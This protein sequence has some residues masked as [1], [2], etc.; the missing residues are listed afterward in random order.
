MAI[1]RIIKAAVER[2]ASDVHIKAGD[3]VRARIDGRLVVLTKQALTAEQ[4]RAIALHFMMSDAE[5]GTID[6]LKDHDCS[7][8][9][10]GVGRFRVNIMRQRAAHSIVMRVIPEIVPTFQS[11]KLPPVLDR[12][13]H[14]ERGMVLVTGVTG[15]GKSSTMAALVNAINASQEKHILTLENPIEFIHADLKSSVTQ[16]EVGID[17]ESFRMGLRAA[18]RQDPDVILIGEMRDPETIDTAMKAAE[19]GHLLISTLHTPDAQSTIMRIVAMF[20]PDEQTVVRMR[21]AESLHAVVSQ[22][23]MPRANGQGRVLACEVMIVTSTIRDLIA[24]GN[25]VEIR[26]YIADGAQ[27][28][29]RTFDQHLTELVN[30]NEVTFEVAKAAATNPADFELTF[31]MGKNRQS[32]PAGVR[33]IA[34]RPTGSTKSVTQGMSAVA[35]P[36]SLGANPLGTGPTM[37]PIATSPSGHSAVSSPNPLGN[38]AVFGSGFESLFGS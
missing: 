28:G 1:E 33:G 21:L 11:L 12:I 34:S 30:S 9:S 3:V 17:T 22:R 19:T 5:R 2:G 15:S 16:R 37:P 26:D 24:E 29:M 4:T 13:A 18:L 25:I 20:P 31:R 38:D 7:W 6:S 8:H 14:T 23:L 10:P 27:Y 36:N 35:T 32:P